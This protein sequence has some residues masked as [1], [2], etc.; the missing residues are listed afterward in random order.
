MKELLD[1]EM[2]NLIKAFGSPD[3]E[4]VSTAAKGIEIAKRTFDEDTQVLYERANELLGGAKVIN[5]KNFIRG[6]NKI[7]KKNAALQLDQKGLGQV[8]SALA[9]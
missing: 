4:G 5:I 2:D 8:I 1:T 6:W 3:Q 9:K 7:V